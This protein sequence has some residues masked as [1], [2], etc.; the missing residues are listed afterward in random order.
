[1]I[2]KKTAAEVYNCY[3]EIEKGKKLLNDLKES[4]I[5][6]G[7]F[8]LKDS[9]G[10]QRGL[11]LGIPDSDS[12]TR[13]LDVPSELAIDIIERHIKS[14]QDKL[15]ELEKLCIFELQIQ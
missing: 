13:L 10:V 7:E 4:L 8:K 15:K 5:K 3:Y 14:R 2:S 9:F 12:R 6:T 11:Q 1:M